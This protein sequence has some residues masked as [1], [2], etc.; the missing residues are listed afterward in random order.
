MSSSSLRQ[1]EHARKGSHLVLAPELGR[2]RLQHPVSSQLPDD[3]V[4]ALE[5]LPVATLEIKALERLPRTLAAAVRRLGGVAHQLYPQADQVVRDAEH[6]LGF[7][8][9][10]GIDPRPQSEVDGHQHRLAYRQPC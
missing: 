6:L 10:E 5:R 3:F 1:T 2:G 4:I 9:V 7:C 8:R